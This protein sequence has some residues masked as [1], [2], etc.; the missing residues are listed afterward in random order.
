MTCSADSYQVQK[1]V[2]TDAKQISKVCD[3]VYQPDRKEYSE[4]PIIGPPSEPVRG[5]SGLTGY[6]YRNMKSWDHRPC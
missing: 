1:E 2:S 4:T 5:Y 6:L 3:L